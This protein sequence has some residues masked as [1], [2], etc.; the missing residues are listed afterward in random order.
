MTA[1][2]PGHVP[3]TLGAR[4]P[5]HARFTPSIGSEAK[6]SPVT[7]ASVN[8]TGALAGSRPDV[9]TLM[10]EIG[11]RARQA[12]RVLALAPTAQKDEALAG[13]AEALRSRTP[14][15]L[16]ANADDVAEARAS[17]ATPAF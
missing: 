8:A 2:H 1:G 9:P 13:M 15:I 16:A 3:P 4:R 11:R 7:V 17:G 5:K 6:M 10:A 12:A 14:E